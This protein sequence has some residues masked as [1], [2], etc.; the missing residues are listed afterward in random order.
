MGQASSKSNPMLYTKLRAS[1]LASM[2]KPGFGHPRG[3]LVSPAAPPRRRSTNARNRRPNTPALPGPRN[4]ARNR[5]PTPGPWSLL[6]SLRPVTPPRPRRSGRNLLVEQL[7]GEYK[8]AGSVYRK[9]LW[10]TP[11]KREAASQMRLLYKQMVAMAPYLLGKIPPPPP[12][13]Y[14]RARSMLAA[15]SKSPALR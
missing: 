7:A 13:N 11:T 8:K 3:P 6:P 14:N 10:N 1:T 15:R 4:N 5:R 9:Q 2:N 12:S